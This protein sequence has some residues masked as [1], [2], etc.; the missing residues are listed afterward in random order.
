[1]D[2]TSANPL[3]DSFTDSA[4][5]AEHLTNGS[6]FALR[7]IMIVISGAVP[8]N[9]LA[10]RESDTGTANAYGRQDTWECE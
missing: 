8:P 1:M 2:E 3:E 6:R 5:T 9:S 4:T 7:L 10:F